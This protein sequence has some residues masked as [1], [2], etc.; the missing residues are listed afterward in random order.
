MYPAHSN[1]GEGLAS[2]RR[3][4]GLPG[5]FVLAFKDGEYRIVVVDD[6]ASH[7]LGMPVVLPGSVSPDWSEIPP[8]LLDYLTQVLEGLNQRQS[9]VP[10]TPA[11]W[12]SMAEHV[13]YTVRCTVDSHGAEHYILLTFHDSRQ[14]LSASQSLRGPGSAARRPVVVEPATPHPID[15]SLDAAVGRDSGRLPGPATTDSAAAIEH[16]DDAAFARA[17]F[18]HEKME[19][20][21]ELAAG[22]AHDF[23]NLILAIQANAEAIVPAFGLKK[24]EREALVNVLRACSAGAELTRSLL[25]YAKKQPLSMGEFDLCAMVKD[26]TRIASTSL[27]SSYRLSLSA[28]LTVSDHPIKVVGCFSSLSHCLLNL[29]K[30]AKEAMKKGGTISISWGGDAMTA[31]LSVRDEGMGMDEETIQ[32]ILKGRYTTKKEGNGLGLAMVRGILSQHQGTVE[33]QSEV[34]NGS[35]ISLVWPRGYL[36]AT[37]VAPPGVSSHSQ[38]LS[39]QARRSTSRITAVKAGGHEGRLAFVIDDDELVRQ[40]ISAIL[41]RMRFTTR[42]FDRAE[43]AI[44]ALSPAAVPDVILVDYNMPGMDGSEFVRYWHKDL[45]EVYKDKA[46]QI[47]LVS[48][49]PPAQFQQFIKSFPSLDLSVLQKPFSYETLS[50]RLKDSTAPRRPTQQLKVPYPAKKSAAG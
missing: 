17:A 43:A 16:I 11:P 46:T 47:V 24:H 44:A 50:E 45:P 23:N 27:G 41:Q 7:I 1:P 32:R 6:Q 42:E 28:E 29:I 25:G 19:T 26:V 21:G 36:A 20:I 2:V 37:V 31:R 40:G 48:G 30:N 14:A 13:P 9:G 34:G 18:E 22:V 39:V 10:F 5:E 33:I 35:E 49:Y 38:V 4:C 15:A 3:K 12:Y 8:L